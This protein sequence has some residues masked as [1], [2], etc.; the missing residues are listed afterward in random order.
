MVLKLTVLNGQFEGVTVEV[1]GALTIGR[2]QDAGLFLPDPQV[3][4][5]HAFIDLDGALYWVRDNGSH[6]G[7]YVNEIRL[8][9]RR[10]LR[11]GDVVRLGNSSLEVSIPEEEDVSASQ[12]IRIEEEKRDVTM[13]LERAANELSPPTIDDITGSGQAIDGFSF[14]SIAELRNA[15]DRSLQ[16][17]LS[18][19]KRFAILFHV[20]RSLQESTDAERLL[21]VMMDHVFKVMKADHG[22]IVLVNPTTGELVP[23][24]SMDKQGKISDTV[25]ISRTVVKKALNSRMAIISTDARSDPRLS[26]AESIIMYG[27]RSIMCVP[28]ISQESVI[29]IVQVVN[30]KDMAAFGEDDLYLLTV[31]ASL[32]AVSIENA[33]LYE[34][35]KMALEDA[36]QAHEDLMQA[37]EELIKREKLATVGQLAAGIAHEIKNSLGPMA[38]VHLLKER[39]PDDDVLQEYAD[40]ILESHNRIRGIVDEVRNFTHGGDSDTREQ[41][42][43]SRCSLKELLESVVAFLKFDADVKKVGVKLHIHEPVECEV[44]AERVK[45]VII[46]L[47]RNS[48]QAVSGPDGKIDVVLSRDG[49]DAMIRVVD[50]GCGIPEDHLDSIWTPFFTTKEGTGMGLGL[51]ISRMIIEQHNGRMECNSKPGKGTIMSIVLPAVD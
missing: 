33:R 47:I 29:G 9:N 5:A 17:I 24:L 30:E 44:S 42:V 34:R 16:L 49:D 14:P 43:V 20:A 13:T 32:A 45:Q 26:D 19:A 37:Q 46:N 35:Q 11:N 21:A 31:I 22:E 8:E 39:H 38:L 51:D 41:H 10:V 4:R 48:A 25:R 6:N 23:V 1:E 7:T 15:P 40:M 36:R 28:M 12:R 3:S 2:A 27:M 50:N 18:N